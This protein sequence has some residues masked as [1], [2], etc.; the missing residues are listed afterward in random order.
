MRK[1][2]SFL[3]ILSFASC[4]KNT[5]I[6]YVYPKAYLPAYPGSYWDY[7][8][9]ERVLTSKEYVEHQYEESINSNQKTPKKYVPQYMGQYLYEYDV[10]QNSTTYPLKKLLDEE[11]GKS[12][13][14]NKINNQKIFRKIIEKKAEMR[15]PFP[16]FNK[17]IDS[18]I[19]DILVV[20]EYIDT[21]GEERWNSREYYAKNIGLIRIDINNP[22]DENP[23]VVQKQIQG[24]H[25]N[26]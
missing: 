26:K 23:P 12:W 10:T 8:N 19:K 25:I 4:K 3:L 1:T 2:L 13:E 6:E 11:V 14:V 16:P 18:L 20:V 24:Y 7:T 21:L 9:G 22:F 5:E 15:I 17:P